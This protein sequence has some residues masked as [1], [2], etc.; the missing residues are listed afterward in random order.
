MI[1]TTT[2]HFKKGDYVKVKDGLNKDRIGIVIRCGKGIHSDLIFTT[3]HTTQNKFIH[4]LNEA[5]IKVKPSKADKQK[6]NLLIK[7]RLM[8]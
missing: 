3:I 7:L 5:F 6:I 2:Y 1:N 8:K 4:G